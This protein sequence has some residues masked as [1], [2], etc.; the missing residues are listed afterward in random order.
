[1]TANFCERG[2]TK[3]RTALRSARLIHSEL[4][5]FLLRAIGRAIASQLRRVE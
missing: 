3:M 1:M 5:K 2:A 4:E